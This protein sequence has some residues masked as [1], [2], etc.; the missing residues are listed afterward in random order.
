MTWR[1]V[2]R[3][4][5]RWMHGP[6]SVMFAGRAT[7]ECRRCGERFENPALQGALNGKTNVY[8]RWTG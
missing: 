7:Y 1:A 2:R 3:W 6:S 5:C 8:G 4:W